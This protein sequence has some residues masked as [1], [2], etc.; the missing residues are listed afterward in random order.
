MKESV[1][2]GDAQPSGDGTVPEILVPLDL[3]P[4]S[5]EAVHTAIGYAQRLRARILLLHVIDVSLDFL[6]AARADVQRIEQD[7]RQ[8]ATHE[9]NWAMS[10]FRDSGVRFETMIVEGLPGHKIVNLAQDRNVLLIIMG[11]HPAPRTWSL[12]HRQ[13]VKEVLSKAECEIIVVMHKANPKRKQAI[14]LGGILRKADQH[15]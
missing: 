13:T 14:A 6:N 15:L 9:F 2:D 1:L 11:R 7:I 8:Q 12:F 4:C 5:R 10:M 3:T